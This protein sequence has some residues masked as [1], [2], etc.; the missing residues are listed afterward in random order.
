MF[1]CRFPFS[2]SVVGPESLPSDGPGPHFQQ[3]PS[4]QWE[5]LTSRAA[6][7]ARKWLSSMGSKVDNRRARLTFWDSSESDKDGSLTP[8]Y[9]QRI[10]ELPTGTD[11]SAQ[12]S[13]AGQGGLN[14]PD[15][16]VSR[17]CHGEAGDPI[18]A[19]GRERVMLGRG[20]PAQG[21]APALLA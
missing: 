9:S 11:R 12:L 20:R 17:G 7:G 19:S 5:G 15:L 14:A 10:L 13:K 1:K 6:S 8:V 21:P 16:A 18:V 2:R 3:R 4:T